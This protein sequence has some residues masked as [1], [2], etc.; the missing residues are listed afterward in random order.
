MEKRRTLSVRRSK[1]ICGLLAQLLSDLF[2]E[3]LLLLLDALA[4]LKADGVL[5]GNGA[6]QSLGNGG[7]ILL[8][9]HG[10]ILHELLLQQAVLLVELA[11]L[12]GDD[13]LLDLL[14]L[15]LLYTSDAADD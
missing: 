1:T 6:A 11:Q 9:G 10:V 2:G 13:A 5:E 7:D 14:G 3:V 15:C 12:T 4:L 8:H